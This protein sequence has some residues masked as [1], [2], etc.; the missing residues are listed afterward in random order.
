MELPG[1]L[2]TLMEQ[3]ERGD[4]SAAETLA[5][6]LE[7]ALRLMLRRALRLD[8]SRS[9][10]TERLQSRLHQ[11]GSPLLGRSVDAERFVSTAAHHLACDAGK[12]LLAKCSPPRWS[13]DT[14]REQG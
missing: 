13:R 9:G 10:L 4:R 14:V 6:E 2:R 3:A 8:R 11:I 12:R 5:D 1:S 7:P